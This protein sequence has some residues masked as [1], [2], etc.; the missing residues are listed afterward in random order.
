MQ[1]IKNIEEEVQSIADGPLALYCHRLEKLTE[2]VIISNPID[3]QTTS[4]AFEFL[5]NRF[6]P[7]LI[8]FV[9][10]GLVIIRQESCVPQKRL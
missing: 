4:K 8:D 9:K 5:L 7:H 1:G 2:W 6:G 10:N 3:C